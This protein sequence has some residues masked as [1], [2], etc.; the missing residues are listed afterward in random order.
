MRFSVRR[1]YGFIFAEMFIG[2]LVA[3]LIGFLV[4]HFLATSQHSL[5]LVGKKNPWWDLSWIRQKS[6][7]GFFIAFFTATG[8][9]VAILQGLWTFLQWLSTFL[10]SKS[11]TTWEEY[12]NSANHF[13][14]GGFKILFHPFRRIACLIG[15]K[16]GGSERFP[17]VAIFDQRQRFLSENDKIIMTFPWKVVKFFI[18]IAVLGSWFL[19]MYVFYSYATTIV[20]GQSA[21]NNLWIYF[22]SSFRIFVHSILA[23]FMVAVSALVASRFSALYLLHLDN[24][25]YDEV[26]SRLDTGDF[27]ELKDAISLM[28]EKIA[29]LEQVVGNLVR[30]SLNM[31]K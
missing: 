4:A 2:F 24:L 9:V 1:Y 21:V 26:L 12:G 8:I 10:V 28:S 11:M 20:S 15:N 7:W 23:G 30:I 17:S 3:I 5:L 16:D 14:A 29:R 19:S 25:V 13:F 6:P 27:Q 22:S 31:N 18:G